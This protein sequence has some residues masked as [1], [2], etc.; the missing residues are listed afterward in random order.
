[1]DKAALVLAPFSEDALALL[2][3][4]V[5]VSHESW[6][7]T[8][9]LLS[10]DEMVERINAEGL[11]ILVVEADYV[12]EE[13]FANAPSL[14]FLGVCRAGL[15]HIDVDAATQ[16]GV[17]VVNTPGRN[18]N[19]VAELALGLMLSLARSIPA[20]ARYVSDGLWEDPVGPYT[21]MR[22]TELGGK[23]LGILGFGAIGRAVGKR[24][25]SFGMKVIA[26]DPYLGGPGTKV[27]GVPLQTL[28]TM[29][30]ASDYLSVHTPDTGETRGLINE[31]NIGLLKH[32]VHIVNTASY[33]TIEEDALVGALRSG[34][35]A[36]VAMDVHRTHPIPPNSPLLTMENALLTPH[37][38]GATAETI[39]RQ[40]MMMV[41][42]IR[43][44][45]RGR[46]PR[47]LV[48][49]G[50]WGRLG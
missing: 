50:P 24:A 26:Y 32:G 39:Q 33:W 17:M 43:K 25:R 23:T 49:D 45:L 22:G 7:S 5:R 34:Q 9:E 21:H 12:F 46:R 47:R 36:A 19:A 1:M 4:H 10:T 11:S 8:G 6:L 38:G 44:Y 37:I 30:G 48:N 20:S 42:D 31:D 41:E 16:H 40:S 29:L 14:E 2:R 35:V 28:E 18:A 13:V 3:K 15:G 27:G